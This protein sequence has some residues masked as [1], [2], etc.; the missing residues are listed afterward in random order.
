MSKIS[1]SRP[2]RSAESKNF[3]DSARGSVVAST[4]RRRRAGLPM[5]GIAATGSFSCAGTVLVNPSLTKMIDLRPSRMPPSRD[6]RALE[7]AHR[8]V[9][10]NPLDRLRRI[11]GVALLELVARLVDALPPLECSI[12]RSA[13]RGCA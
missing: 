12:A 2:I 13:S 5:P 11:I 7:R 8:D 3:C 4:P 6:R 1:R 10:A 9:V